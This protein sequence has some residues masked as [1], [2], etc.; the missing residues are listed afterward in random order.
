MSGMKDKL[1][2]V[3]GTEASPQGVEEVVEPPSPIKTEDLD[4]HS[5]PN[6]ELQSLTVSPALAY[7]E[8]SEADVEGFNDTAGGP[9]ATFKLDM[10]TEMVNQI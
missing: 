10:I 1:Y 4:Q 7:M 3:E 2:E 6:G 5:S 9:E 8:P